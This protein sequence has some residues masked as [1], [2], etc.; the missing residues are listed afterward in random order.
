MKRALL[1]LITFYS[2]TINAQQYFSVSSGFGVSQRISSIKGYYNHKVRNYL[3]PLSI[4]YVT[5]SKFKFS[6]EANLTSKNEDY[7]ILLGSQQFP[8]MLQEYKIVRNSED[9][10]VHFSVGYNLLKKN[11]PLQLFAVL[12]Y[13][14]EFNI[15]NQIKQYRL[16]SNELVYDDFRK[17]AYVTDQLVMSLDLRYQLKRTFLG[18]TIFVYDPI[19]RGN[20]RFLDNP[21]IGI[22]LKVGYILNKK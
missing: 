22:T 4:D 3:V 18:T 5:K 16:P 15:N 11:K 2:L 13:G 20:Y 10:Q 19:Y 17:K 1:I 7:D 9:I 21:Y 12:G 6:V 8:T 14:R